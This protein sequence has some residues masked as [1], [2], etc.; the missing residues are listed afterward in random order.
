MPPPLRP[1]DVPEHPTPASLTRPKQNPPNH[2]TQKKAR[3]RHRLR[4]GC[5]KAVATGACA[6]TCSLFCGHIPVVYTTH[7]TPLPDSHS[8]MQSHLLML[9]PLQCS[10]SPD[11]PASRDR[12]GCF[13][14]G[15]LDGALAETHHDN[16]GN[17]PKQVF[18]L[19]LAA[20]CSTEGLPCS[21]VDPG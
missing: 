1:D 15:T 4:A 18:R 5:R 6:G 7:E 3:D 19:C 13:N 2:S 17:Q 16:A 21:R 14:P 11:T 12:E 8:E 20:S 10:L 9:R